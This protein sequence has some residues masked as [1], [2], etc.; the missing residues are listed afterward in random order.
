MPPVQVVRKR[1]AAKFIGP[2]YRRAEPVKAPS[3]FKPISVPISLTPEMITKFLPCDVRT[4]S[5]VGDKAVQALADA[6][7]DSRIAAEGLAA[8]SRELG[9]DPS[10]SPS[11][12]SDA[13]RSE[14][15]KVMGELAPTLDRA[16][17]SA[18]SK[19]TELEKALM[20]V[21]PKDDDE[22]RLMPELRGRLASMTPAERKDAID[23]GDE[24][25]LRS[26]CAAPAWASGL[27]QLDY[28]KAVAQWRKRAMPEEA[29]HLEMQRKAMAA[30]DR[31][32]AIFTKLIESVSEDIAETGIAA[33]KAART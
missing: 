31:T 20:P 23:I 24:L 6:I 1:P 26:I 17:A 15:L 16:K 4:Q 7:E 3:K 32:G 21:G 14:A 28:D 12:A 33:L 5:V 2:E 10:L 29:A 18:A 22:R 19:I 30:F 27:T 9:A 25:T 11:G 13:L 8:R